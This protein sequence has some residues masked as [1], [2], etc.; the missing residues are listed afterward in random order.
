M[1]SWEEVVAGREV[2]YGIVWI[3]RTIPI[4]SV[5]IISRDSSKDNIYIQ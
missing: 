3:G 1:V 2:G 4:E 5:V